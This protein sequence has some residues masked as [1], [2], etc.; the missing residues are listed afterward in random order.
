LKQR[1]ELR[2]D[3]VKRYDDLSGFL[4]ENELRGTK[5]CGTGTQ[6]LKGVSSFHSHV[7]SPVPVGFQAGWCSNI[8]ASVTRMLHQT[9]I[10]ADLQIYV[11]YIRR[12]ASNF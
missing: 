6:H 9:P 8:R 11:T 10:L 2:R 12:W 1:I 5:E 7:I 3:I 4:A